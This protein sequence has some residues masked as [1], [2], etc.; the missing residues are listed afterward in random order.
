MVL[1]GRFWTVE[2]GTRY[3]QSPWDNVFAFDATTGAI[4]QGFARTWT[5]SCRP[6]PTAPRCGSA[7]P[8]AP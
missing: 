1:G 5:A 7:G 3:T 2:N 6:S 4:N 8:S